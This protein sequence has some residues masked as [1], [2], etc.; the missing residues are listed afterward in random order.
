MRQRA[1][2]RARL[3]V[4]YDNQME[5]RLFCPIGETGMVCV[6]P[7]EP[8][9]FADTFGMH[10]RRAFNRCART[11]LARSARRCSRR[12]RDTLTDPWQSLPGESSTELAS[13][14]ELRR[15]AAIRVVATGSS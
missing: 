4:L 3:F 5:D 13:P 10:S 8:R 9:R 11:A 2:P 15:G 12:R 14:T 6:A 1:W 7:V